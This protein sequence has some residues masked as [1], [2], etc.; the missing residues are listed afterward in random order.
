M[1]EHGRQN[2]RLEQVVEVHMG[3][4]ARPS[5]CCYRTTNKNVISIFNCGGAEGVYELIIFKARRGAPPHPPR[6]NHWGGRRQIPGATLS[7][8]SATVPHSVLLVLSFYAILMVASV[9]PVVHM[10]T[11]MLCS[12]GGIATRSTM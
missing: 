4:F 8:S 9:A 3:H 11:R 6:E 1:E 12:R 10:T 2:R 5:F 7:A